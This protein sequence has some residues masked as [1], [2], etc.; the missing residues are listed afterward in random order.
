MSTSKIQ[1]PPLS[2]VRF[3]RSSRRMVCRSSR[4]EAIR[5]GIEVLLVDRLQQHDDRPLENLVLQGGNSDRASLGSRARLGNVHTPHRRCPVRPGLRPV[6]ERLEVRLQVLRVLGPGLSVHARCP[7]FAGPVEGRFQPVDVHQIGQRSESHLRRS[8]RQL[9][10]PLLFREYAHRIS[11]YSAYVPTTSSMIP[12]PR[13]PPRG[14]HGRLFPRFLGT[15]KALRLPA[16]PPAA[17][18]CLRLAVPREHAPFAPVA[19][20]CGRRRAWG[21]SPG[22]PVRECFRGDDRISQVPGEPLFPFAHVLGPRPADP[23]QTIT[24]TVAWPPLQRTTKAPTSN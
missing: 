11:R 19:V 17:L 16:G 15:I 6:Q 4:P 2:I 22:I 24:E 3:H 21:W 7:V 1:P 5:A 13:F 8:F 10:Y 12:M 20:A 23:S 18:R 9:G 14:P